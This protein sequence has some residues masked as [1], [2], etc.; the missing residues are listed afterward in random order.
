MNQILICLIFLLAANIM[1]SDNTPPSYALSTGEQDHERLSILNEI[2]NPSS[3][4][5]LEVVPGCRVLTIGCG[6]GLL[7]LEIAKQT[8]AEGLV[9][10]TDINSDQLRIAEKNRK[11]AN[12]HQLQFSQMD[13]LDV[14]K[15][16]GLFDRIHCRF[17]LTHLPLEKAF[18]IL[19]LLYKKIAPGGFLLL[20]EIATIDSLY[21]DP[22]HPCY[23]K[24]K[25]EVQ[26]QFL[27]QGSDTSPGKRIFKYLQEKGYEVSYSSY[28]PVLSSPRE[29]NIL[30]LGI[31][32]LSKKLLENQLA[33]PEEIEET[34][35]LLHHLEQDSSFFPR[36]NEVSQIKVRKS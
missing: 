18:Q 7:E 21:C 8:T 19:D 17:V 30:A 34:L 28:Q 29:K 26:R 13:A 36:Y 12:L 35:S 16:P 14:E 6:I 11:N 10:A 4:E 3:L 24:W 33:L 25:K 2:H 32:S 9:V 20:E 31:L 23:E 22:V 27:L 15:I 1:H 5:L